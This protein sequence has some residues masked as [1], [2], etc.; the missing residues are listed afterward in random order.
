MATNPVQQ[1]LVKPTI[2]QIA[3]L[4]E[5]LCNRVGEFINLEEEKKGADADYNKHMGEIWG[6]I[7]GL[8][9]RIKEAEEAI[10]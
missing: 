3:A 1:L 5:K 8:R 6:E 2:E 4:R 7:V 9:A 10:G